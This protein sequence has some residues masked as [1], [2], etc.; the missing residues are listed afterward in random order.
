MLDKSIAYKSVVM[1]IECD[2][3]EA[4]GEATLPDGFSFRFFERS[5]VK[6]WGSIETS[7]LEF[8]SESEACSY[9]EMAYLPSLLELQKRCFFIINPD[10][11]PIATATAW[12]SDSELGYQPILHWVAVRPEYQRKGLGKA[13][14]KKALNVFR[15]LES[16]KPVWLQTQTWSYPA[17]RLYHS[18]GFNIV[19]DER[20]VNMNTKDG[21]PKIYQTEFAEAMQVLRT[22]MKDSYVDEL[23]NTAV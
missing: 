14:T 21:V 18:L 16:G 11:I 4:L 20:S 15:S 10:G 22:V 1:R 5:D 17:I 6:H 19:K 7:V 3:I 13:L 23:I 2:K 12:Y 9:F 8:P